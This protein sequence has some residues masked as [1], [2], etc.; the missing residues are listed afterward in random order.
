MDTNMSGGKVCKYA[1]ECPVYNEEIT[2]F[3]VPQ[4]IIKNV[5]CNRGAKG[6]KNCTRYNMME[7][8]QEVPEGATPYAGE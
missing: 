8:N 5:F 6:W 1:K 7:E 2:D 4:H 3:E